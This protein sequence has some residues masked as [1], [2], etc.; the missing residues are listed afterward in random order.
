MRWILHLN[1]VIDINYNMNVE[2]FSA[3]GS[4]TPIYATKSAVFR[5]FNPLNGL[6]YQP[7]PN[8]AHCCV[9][10][11]HLIHQVQKCGEQSDL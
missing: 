7:K 9:S 10:P 6:L 3:F 11:S 8:N 2:I 5:Q 1:L 4:K